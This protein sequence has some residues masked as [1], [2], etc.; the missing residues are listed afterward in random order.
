M[1]ERVCPLRMAGATPEFT[2]PQNTCKCLKEEC[3]WWVE[4]PNKWIKHQ[5]GN[6]GTCAIAVLA[7]GGVPGL[8]RE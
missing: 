6:A 4:D 5:P 3:M 7:M 1:S 8:E 2:I